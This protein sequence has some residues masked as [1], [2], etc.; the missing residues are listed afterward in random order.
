MKMVLVIKKNGIEDN[1]YIFLI[2]YNSIKIHSF[3]CEEK[4]ISSSLIKF[5]NKFQ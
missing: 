3:K 5:N 1:I 4:L 2:V